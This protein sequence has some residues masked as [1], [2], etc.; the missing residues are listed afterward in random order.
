MRFDVDDI[1]PF[2]PLEAAN[3]EGLLAIGGDLSPARL[4]LAYRSGIFPWY[5]EADPILWWSPDPRCVIFPEEFRA[6]RSLKKSI[7]NRGYRFSTDTAFDE[8]I[9]ACAGNRRNQPGTWLSKSMQT[10][11]RQLSILGVAHSAEVWSGDELVG[12][13]YGIALGSVFFGESMFS[14]K[15]DAS[16]VAYALL[17]ERLLAWGFTLV[18]C[19]VSSPHIMRIGARE[20]PRDEFMK[21]LECSLDYKSGSLVGSNWGES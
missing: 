12:G 14:R 20:I 21:R 16:K 6:S 2:P 8:V 11:Y 9:K 19:Q 1:E 3:P 18:D 10:A 7:R 13:L 17:N 15:T 5:N 4:V